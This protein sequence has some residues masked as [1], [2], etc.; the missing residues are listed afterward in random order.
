MYELQH[1][2]WV[3]D[4]FQ[5]QF[6]PMNFNVTEYEQLIDPTLQLTFNYH[7]SNLSIVSKNIQ[8]HLQGLLQ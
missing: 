2:T 1:H 8:N 3:E 4:P 5:V 7:L 6:R